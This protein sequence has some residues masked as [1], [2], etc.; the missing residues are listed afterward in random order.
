MD[1]DITAIHVRSP[2]M[3]DTAT[4]ARRSA[5]AVSPAM[6]GPK[7]HSISHA[8]TAIAHSGISIAEP[9]IGQ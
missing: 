2:T 7:G 4:H 1:S 3:T 8:R 6:I 9:L 5:P